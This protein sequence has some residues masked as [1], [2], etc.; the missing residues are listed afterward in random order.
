MIK[1]KISSDLDILFK[2]KDDTIVYN[3]FMIIFNLLLYIDDDD[4][5]N[6]FYEYLNE[7]IFNQTNLDQNNYLTLMNKILFFFKNEIK[8][9]SKL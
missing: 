8:K 9:F 2:S 5:K 1:E 3:G 4:D 6:F 7:N